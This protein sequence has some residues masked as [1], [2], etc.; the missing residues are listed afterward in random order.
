MQPI[1]LIAAACLALISAAPLRAN[2]LSARKAEMEQIHQSILARDF[3]SLDR[4]ERAWRVQRSRT[5][6]GVW[7]LEMFYDAMWFLGK[8]ASAP[9]CTDPAR[10]FLA[11]W[12][13]HSPSSPAPF[14]ASASRLL[15]TGWCYRGTGSAASVD[16]SA[17]TQFHAYAAAA[18]AMLASHK[19]VA[20]ADPHYYVIM[21]SIAVAE[22]WSED[23]FGA[24]LKEAVK[25]E[26]YYYPLYDEAFRYYEPRWF[27]SVE[28]EEALAQFA[29]HQ[30]SAKDRTSVFARIYWS[31]MDCGCLP[32]AETPNKPAL[33][34]AMHDLA[35]L[36]PGSWNIAHMAKLACGIGDGELAR[37]YFEAL[38]AGDDGQAGWEKWDGVDGERWQ[39]CRT[40]A[41]VRS[42]G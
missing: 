37:H 1:R 35:E 4:T 18:H 12:R 28:A 39:S 17:W 2:E 42:D 20:S 31:A 29:V 36:Y 10:P 38:P 41:G 16:P 3:A 19:A 11:E 32:S 8:P 5:P 33:R 26:P 34:Q 22:G 21:A 15:D 23:A 40:I 24:L 14:I 7:K 13:K 30:T 27:G 6:S 9:D 25:R